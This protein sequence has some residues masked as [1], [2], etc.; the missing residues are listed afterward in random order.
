MAFTF[1]TTTTDPTAVSIDGNYI[2][3]AQF[4]Y[5]FYK[6][7][8]VPL[9]PVSVEILSFWVLHLQLPILDSYLIKTEMIS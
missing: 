5:I 8:V 7:V 4:L 9:P 1:N 6:R 2:T 3:N